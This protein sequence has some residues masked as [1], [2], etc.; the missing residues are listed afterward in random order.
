MRKE[1]IEATNDLANQLFAAEAAID[2]AITEMAKLS[3]MMPEA[4]IRVKVSAS[5]GHDAMQHASQSLSSLVEARTGIVSVHSAL[6]QAKTDIG[7]RTYGLGGGW[8]KG[9]SAASSLEIVSDAA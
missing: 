7:L 2:T 1:R 4:R 6:D 8:Q 3:A 9:P 5:L